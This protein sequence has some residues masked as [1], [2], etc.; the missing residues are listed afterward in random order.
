MRD[1]AHQILSKHWGYD[2]FRPG[3]LAIVESLMQGNDTLA[4]LPTGGGK[5]ICFQ[6]PAVS[7]SGTTLVVSP[8]IALMKDQVETLNRKGIPAAALHAGLSR[9][10]IQNTLEHALHGTFKLLYVSPE[11]LATQNFRGY[12]PNLNVQLLVVDEAHC[13]SMWGQDFRPSY[14]RLSELRQLL[15]GIPMAAFTASAPAWI[16]D[17]IIQGLQLRK[18]YI[19]R[20]DFSRNNLIFHALESQDKANHIVRILGRSQ[21]SALV[22]GHTRKSVENLC[23]ILI[24]KGIS[25][26]FYHAGL[27][28]S[29][30]SE[31]QN[32]WVHNTVRVMVCTNAFGMGV[33]KPDVRLV[34]HSFPPKNPEDYYQEAG[35]AGRDGQLSHCVLLHHPNDWKE[36]H[37]S[38]LQQHPSEEILKHAYHGILNALGISD[39]EGEWQSHPVNLALIA[40]Q[41]NLHPKNL[42]Y[43]V[44]ALEILGQWQWMEGNWQP[45]TVMMTG[46]HDEIYAFKEQHPA[47]GILLDSLLRG[48]GGIFDH[49]VNIHEAS[50]A[51]RLRKGDFDR[52]V[53]NE[54]ILQVQRM[55]G[56]M[57]KLQLMRYQ[58]ATEWPMLSLTES[59]SLYPSL[60]M[61]LLQ[62]LLH[63][64]LEALDQ[65]IHYAQSNECRSAFWRSHFTAETQPPSCGTC[66]VCKRK[67]RIAGDARSRK[68]WHNELLKHPNSKVSYVLKHFPVTQQQL[69]IETLRIMLDEGCIIENENQT[70]SWV[71]ES[72]LQ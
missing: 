28:N 70:L 52:E 31:R 19:H 71:G 30:R 43:A 62:R 72:F 20:G 32:Q 4:L 9:Q 38:L 12:L 29:E 17:D 33:D 63:R 14:Q 15:P 46:P 7:K 16:Q 24:E 3:Q 54:E 37:E 13:I 61:P 69:L 18:P 58:P 53:S 41:L 67:D 25:A 56:Q 8:L 47:Y 66:D 27:S 40:Q 42:Y 21:G 36:I 51:R 59:R 48:H 11:R 49:P 57:E 44:K 10:E 1:L 26:S 34:I 5:S 45:A 6:V 68:F 23:R 39:G 35:R 22:F 2:A 60:N 64:R 50:L 65:L 55:L